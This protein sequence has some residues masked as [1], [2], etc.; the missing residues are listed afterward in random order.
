MWVGNIELNLRNVVI[1]RSWNL[2]RIDMICFW[3]LFQYFSFLFGLMILHDGV[4]KCNSNNLK[5][6]ISIFIINFKAW[7][8]ENFVMVQI[9]IFEVRF[10]FPHII[11]VGFD[12]VPRGKTRSAPNSYLHIY[13]ILF[14]S[15]WEIDNLIYNII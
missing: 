9:S 12:H 15:F 8:V 4:E 6:N 11:G 2:H 13:I 1:A 3:N 5:L 7:N 10:H 14:Q